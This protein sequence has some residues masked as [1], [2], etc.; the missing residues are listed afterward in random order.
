MIKITF[1]DGNIKSFPKGITVLEV[2][3]DISI[4]LAKKSLQLNLMRI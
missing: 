4:S 1:P 2:A 3:E